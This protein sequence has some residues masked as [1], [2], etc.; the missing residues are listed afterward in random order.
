MPVCEKG[1]D[2]L[3]LAIVGVLER[4][5]VAD[6]ELAQP[7]QLQD[8]QASVKLFS[9][10]SHI[11]F[12]WNLC[13]L[14]QCDSFVIESCEKPKSPVICKNEFNMGNASIFVINGFYDMLY[15]EISS[16]VFISIS[17]FYLNWFPNSERLY[18]V[19]YFGSRISRT[20]RVS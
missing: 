19:R 2:S 7:V 15:W 16:V 11:I 18:F 6:Q 5:R 8:L 1:I 17:V 14:H 20:S 12:K 13:H 9:M 10:T 4:P 3:F